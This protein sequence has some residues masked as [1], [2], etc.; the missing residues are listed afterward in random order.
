MLRAASGVIAMLYKAEKWFHVRGDMNYSFVWIMGCVTELAKVEVYSAG[1]IAGR[2]VV[3]QA[4]ELNP[5]FFDAIYTDLIA[6][7]KSP[8]TIAAAL[9][10][11]DDYLTRRTRMLF[12]PILEHLK[13]VGVPRS[14]TELETHFA[15]QM[16]VGEVVT[17]CEWLADKEV[18]NKVSTPIRLTEKS[19]V[20]FEELAFYYDGQG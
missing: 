12:G 8:K 20:A 18:I 17:A 3:Q 10:Q 16:G 15:N 19:A 9:A 14:A 4:L 7:K 1:Q 2:E 5:K 13:E 11:I 6:A